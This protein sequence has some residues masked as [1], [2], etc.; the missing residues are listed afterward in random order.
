MGWAALRSQSLMR[1]DSLRN[2][3]EDSRYK[4]RIDCAASI[5]SLAIA[6]GCS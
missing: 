5:C 4:P 1:K 6:I 2:E 3:N